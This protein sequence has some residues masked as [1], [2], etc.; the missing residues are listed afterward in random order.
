MFKLENQFP[1]EGAAYAVE[2]L[3]EAI[4]VDVVLHVAIVGMVE[5]V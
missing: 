1:V 5:D 2:E 4:T 3:A